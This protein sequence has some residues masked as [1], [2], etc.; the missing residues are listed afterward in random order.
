MPTGL[1]HVES[2]EKKGR[3]GE[4]GKEIQPDGG[5]GLINKFY[6]VQWA[7]KSRTPK[8]IRRG[9]KNLSPAANP[10]SLTQEAKKHIDASMERLWAR[11]G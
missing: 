10:R 2:I 11:G 9:K 8:G 5:K 3:M 6:L 1:G 7:E 4:K